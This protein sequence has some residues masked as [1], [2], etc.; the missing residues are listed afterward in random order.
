MRWSVVAENMNVTYQVLVERKFA[1][2]KEYQA[3]PSLML[4]VDSFANGK[5]VCF[6]RITNM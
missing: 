6:G 2:S 4:V 1:Q 3:D 5:D